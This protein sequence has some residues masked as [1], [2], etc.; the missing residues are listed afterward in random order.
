MS[1]LPLVATE[2]QDIA[3]IDSFG[4]IAIVP[5]SLPPYTIAA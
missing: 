3:R 5:A 4:P 1:G 2:R